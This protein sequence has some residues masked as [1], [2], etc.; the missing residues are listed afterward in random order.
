[1]FRSAVLVVIALGATT[2]AARSVWAQACCASAGLVAPTRLRSYED[3][4]VGLQAKGRSVFG[5]FSGAGDYRVNSAEE[6]EWD[7]EQDLFAVARVFEHGQVSLLIPFVQTRRAVPGASDLGGG[8]GDVAVSARYDVTRTGER[9][10]VPGLA[11]LAGVVAPTGTP[12]ESATGDLAAD[13]TGQGTFEGIVGGAVEQAFEPYFAALTL[14]LGWRASRSVGGVRE[15][16]APR[17]TA[18]LSA[19]RVLPRGFT[20]GAYVSALRQGE[21]S[22]DVRGRIAGSDLALLTAGVAF[23][24]AASDHWRVQGTLFGNLPVNGLGRNQTA[25]WGGTLSVIRLWL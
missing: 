1:M 24:A 8:L 11:V 22:D 6:S 20:A 4:A 13:A 19:G 3:F 2:C 18:T 17:F 9:R 21:N 12:P 16:F 5:A 15:S 14:A 7:L 25:G 23:T 10:F